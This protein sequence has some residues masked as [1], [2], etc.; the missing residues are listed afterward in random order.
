MAKDRTGLYPGSFDP[1]TKGHIDIIE[2]AAK[3]FDVVVTAVAANS[4]KEPLFTVE[5]RIEMLEEVT[6]HLENVRVDSFC[7][8]TVEFAQESGA[9]AIVRGI[10][11][12]SDFEYEFQMALTNRKLAADIETLFFM[13]SEE[14]FATS[15][16]L[17]KEIAQYGGDLSPFLTPTVA[18]R[19]GKKMK[20]T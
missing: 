16:S 13:P 11:A 17:L 15:S 9:A 2:R 14:H 10:R 12:L 6:S 8:L 20:K 18:E 19:F 7:G 5:E 1:V 4:A 3:M